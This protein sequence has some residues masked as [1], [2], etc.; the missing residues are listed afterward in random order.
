MDQG[1]TKIDVT[2]NPVEEKLSCR[3]T[4]AAFI[5]KENNRHSSNC[6]ICVE[7]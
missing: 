1:G 7:E 6:N 4:F 5:L 2:Q 3:I